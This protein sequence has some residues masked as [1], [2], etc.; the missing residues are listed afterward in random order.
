[1]VENIHKI[2]QDRIEQRR[3]FAEEMRDRAQERLEQEY[4]K[5]STQMNAIERRQRAENIEFFKSEIERAENELE[6]IERISE[7]IEGD[8]INSAIAQDVLEILQGDHNDV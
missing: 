4:M 1:M 5:D 6:E 8:A 2:V 7:R 3:H